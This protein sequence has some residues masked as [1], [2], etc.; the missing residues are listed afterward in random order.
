MGI[1]NLNLILCLILLILE[2]LINQI[3]QT[4]SRNRRN[5]IDLFNVEVGKINKYY[6]QKRS[7]TFGQ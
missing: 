3:N 2:G 4:E 5:Q 7:R 1:I 6:Y